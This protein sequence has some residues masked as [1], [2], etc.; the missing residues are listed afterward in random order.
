MQSTFRKAASR[1]RLLA[2]LI[3]FCLFTLAVPI[4]SGTLESGVIGETGQRDYWPA[5]SQRTFYGSG[6]FWAFWF[7]GSTSGGF[8][9]YSSSADGIIWTSPN[10]VN[11]GWI[12]GSR[13]Y[14]VWFDGAYVNNV[15]SVLNQN[16]R[17]EIIYTRGQINT[18]GTI[19]WDLD[20]SVLT[21]S[22][23]I[24]FDFVQIS[25]DSNDCP[26][27]AYETYNFA[28]GSS[29][30]YVVMS[31]TND[32][33]WKTAPDF[34]YQLAY[35]DTTGI[36][37]AAYGQGVYPLTN[38]K[39]AVFYALQNV[40]SVQAWTGSEWLP[41]VNLTQPVYGEHGGTWEWSAVSQGD[42][43]HIAF[44]D[45]GIGYVRYDYS[46]NNFSN[47]THLPVI[48]I[49]DF[50]HVLISLDKSTSNIYIFYQNWVGG[51]V[52]PSTG[53][54]YVSRINEIWSNAPTLLVN[55][56]MPSTFSDTVS[57]QVNDGFISIMYNQYP[58]YKVAFAF[59]KVSQITATTT[60]T[61]NSDT[62]SPYYSNPI[63]EC[64]LTIILLIIVVAA[65]LFIR[66]QSPARRPFPSEKSEPNSNQ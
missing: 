51:S 35:R 61:P 22:S 7:N 47:V 57:N 37:E 8:E 4:V 54:Y 66:A 38:G 52:S 23:T 21:G 12:T 49:A 46:T 28:D 50:D 27:I 42:S 62:N 55:D 63:L 33:T 14:S 56:T 6:R 31:L 45:S 25:T 24:M 20:Q 41:E 2:L 53:I 13:T 9:V 16:N 32:G 19:T 40:G 17:Y 65:V 48:G 58:V 34:P 64:A 43:L 36:N 39:M 15:M 11:R 59:L 60:P 3:I 18:D 44:L 5:C 1:S 29:Y 30:P 26:W 10:T